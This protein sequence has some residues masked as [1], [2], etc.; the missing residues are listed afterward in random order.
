MNDWRSWFLDP[1]LLLIL[2]IL[3]GIGLGLIAGWLVW[4][5]SYYD[6]DVYDLR[7]DY[8]DDFVVMVGALNA[9]EQ[10][11]GS[12][13]GRTDRRSRSGAPASPQAV[14][15]R[16]GAGRRRGGCGRAAVRELPPAA[17]LVARPAR[18][19]GARR[20]RARPSAES[21]IIT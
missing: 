8:Q 1:R 13:R 7:A 2:G 18:A 3:L 20:G 15:R 4:P 21:G 16:P 10:D 11:V 14:G 5:V 17:P 6:T 19:R 9:L 12:S